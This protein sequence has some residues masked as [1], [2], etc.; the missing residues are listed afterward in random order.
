MNTDGSIEERNYETPTGLVDYTYFASGAVLR[1][2]FYIFGGEN[3]PNQYKKV[4]YE[5]QK[6]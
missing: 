3:G 6:S 2:V 5:F 4:S 1:G